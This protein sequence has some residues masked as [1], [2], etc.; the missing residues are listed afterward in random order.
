MKVLRQVKG[1]HVREGIPIHDADPIK[2]TPL[3]LENYEMPK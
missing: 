2:A 3:F 1:R